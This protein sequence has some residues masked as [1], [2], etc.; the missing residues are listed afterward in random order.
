MKKNG[1]AEKKDVPRGW[2]FQIDGKP[3]TFI[4]FGKAMAR[5][6]GPNGLIKMVS[7]DTVLK[8]YT[9]GDDV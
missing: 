4:Q 9:D 2:K 8:R 6:T 3:H 5:V 1:D 7:N